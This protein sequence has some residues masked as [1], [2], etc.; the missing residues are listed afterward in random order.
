MAGMGGGV[1]KEFEEET[2]VTGEFGKSVQ[3]PGLLGRSRQED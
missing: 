1:V 2:A 3:L